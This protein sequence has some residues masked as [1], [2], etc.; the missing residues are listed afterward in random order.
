MVLPGYPK[1]DRFE[2]PEALEVYF[3]G[4]DIVCLRCGKKYRTLGVHLQTEDQ[5]FLAMHRLVIDDPRGVGVEFLHL[6][7]GS[8]DDGTGPVAL[9]THVDHAQ[10]AR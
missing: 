1:Q 10:F 5:R 7:L 8:K 6:A 2:T 9:R 3:G 4:A